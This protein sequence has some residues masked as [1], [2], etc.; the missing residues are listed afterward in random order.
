[1]NYFFFGLLVGLAIGW[2]SHKYRRTVQV[3]VLIKPETVFS[4]APPGPGPVEY[5]GP[6]PTFSI[7]KTTTRVPVR[8]KPKRKPRKR[9]H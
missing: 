6:L 9:V 3:P 8:S 2:L 4:E 1:M 5:A 7:T